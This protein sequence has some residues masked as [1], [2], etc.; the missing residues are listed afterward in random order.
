M[1]K[2]SLLLAAF[3]A[4]QILTGQS[5][6]A[7]E[8]EP[9]EEVAVEAAEAAEMPA[10]EVAAEEAGEAPAGAEAAAM[11]E[12]AGV[13]NPLL[14]YPDV[15]SLERSVGFPVFYLPGN[16]LALYHPAQH[17]YSIDRYISDIRFQSVADDSKVT[18]RTALIERIGTEDI[19]GYYGEWEQQSAGDIKRTQVYVAQTA[20]GI[21]VVR[22]TAGRFA[23]AVTIEGVD[24]ATFRH[25][26]KNFVSVADRFSH[27]Y[28]NFKL[29]YKRKTG[30]KPAEEKP[31][32]N[33]AEQAKEQPA[34]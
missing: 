31:A 22:W 8:A 7:E 26:V 33:A 11:G 1:K 14:E 2:K 3:F 13:G 32:E 27:K 34:K 19:S 16:M 20:T 17:I 10:A 18:V 4:A 23:F 12:T 9:A 25:M 28:R 6:F 15:P 21:H 24:D 5:A 29:N 30:D